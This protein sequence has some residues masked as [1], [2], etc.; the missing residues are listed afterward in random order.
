MCNI[1]V[2]EFFIDNTEIEEFRGK[3]VLDR[4]ILFSN[5]FNS[6][7]ID[8]YSTKTATQSKFFAIFNAELYS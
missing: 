6:S 4:F 1:A 3:R 5:Y 7:C 2:I 8:V